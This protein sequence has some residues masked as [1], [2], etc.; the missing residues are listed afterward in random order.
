M[1]SDIAL[2]RFSI[3]SLLV[4]LTLAA[5]L[6]AFLQPEG[7]LLAVRG[8]VTI[9]FIEGLAAVAIVELLARNLPTTIR[10]AR[11]ANCRRSDGS[12]SDNRAQIEDTELWK[13]RGHLL[14]AL[15][16]S[17]VP[18]NAV[19]YVVHTR[20]IPIPLAIEAISLVRFP[21]SEW[22]AELESQGVIQRYERL[23]FTTEESKRL[24]GQLWPVVVLL[25]GLATALGFGL[26]RRAHMTSL[27]ELMN[28]IA[29]R[30]A[31]YQFHDLQRYR[32]VHAY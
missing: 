28:A 20:V 22:R 7:T 25:C 9:F 8:P 15:L 19:F 1:N 11:A 12:W 4:V 16:L 3:L 31:G 26:F 2:P 32:D 13:F 14:G 6:T 29:S 24:L 23:R 18:P 30:A 10:R 5:L 17:S 21:M 27:N